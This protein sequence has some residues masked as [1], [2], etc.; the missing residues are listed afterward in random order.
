MNTKE[1]AKIIKIAVREEINRSVKELIKEE[2]T[3]AMGKIIA[4]LILSKGDIITETATKMV[5]KQESPQLIAEAREIPSIKT[6]N[7]KL[8]AILKETAAKHTG[9]PREEH[10]DYSELVGKFDKV[11][12][13]EEIVS[14]QKKEPETNI[15]FLKQMVSPS[16][17]T[18]PSVTE[19]PGAV[20]DSLKKIFKKD[21]SAVLKKMDEVKKS[22][23]RHINPIAVGTM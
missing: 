12:V 14:S 23:T 1:L 16:V 15:D 21:F 17:E 18:T 22:G 11:G 10:V 20:P 8:D 4:E 5:P 13:S 6:G 19:I 9:I 7:P 3:K 2:I